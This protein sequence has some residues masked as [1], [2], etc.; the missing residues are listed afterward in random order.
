[1]NTHADKTPENNSQSVAYS[2]PKPKSSGEST[3]QFVD[4]RPEAIAQRKLHE[5][6]NN[7]PRVKQLKAYQEMAND[8][9][10]V[11]QL[12]VYQAISDN[13]TSQP[14]Q[15]KE[16]LE[17]ETLQGKFEPIQKKENNT[18]LPDNLKSGIENLSG[19]SMDDVKVQ[20]NSDKPSQLQAHAFAQGTHIHIASGQEK[21]LPHEAWHVVQQKQGRVK[22]TMQL[23]D[24][25]NINDD[26]GLEKE[27]DVMGEKALQMKKELDGNNTYQKVSSLNHTIVQMKAREAVVDWLVTHL[28]GDQN[29]SLF[30]GDTE[31]GW[32][33]GELPVEE[34][35][36]ARGQKIVVDDEQIFLSR[37]GS[38]QENP[39]K[40]Q[41]E[42]TKELKHKWYLVLAVGDVNYEG[43]NVYIR[44]ETMKFLKAEPRE[45][46]PMQTVEIPEVVVLGDGISK[47]LTEIKEA[48][49][50]SALKRRRSFLQVKYKGDH[51][52]LPNGLSSGWNW[53]QYDEGQDVAGDM[54]NPGFRSYIK[55][56]QPTNFTLSARYG[57]DPLQAP[58]AFLVM[59]EWQPPSLKEASGHVAPEDRFFYIRWLIGHPELKGGGSAVM[60]RAKEKAIELQQAIYVQVAYSA[61]GW[62]RGTG[63]EVVQEGEFREGEGYGDTLLKYTPPLLPLPH[64]H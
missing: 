62:Y 56:N 58:I 26:A 17:E 34:G 41:A 30:G 7:S 39:E 42:M 25:V 47:R 1:M 38:N 21:H 33:E 48:W 3:L 23:K 10:Q 40:R 35:E 14:A 57:D 53:D 6:I 19:Y 52:E 31:Q 15:R 24:K 45:Q 50:A 36:L 4:I 54:A 55:Q 22:P 12:R 61:V 11:K 18:G 64:P 20:Y 51:N 9:P 8:S 32:Q 27:A 46:R 49:Q 43:K 28:V 2:L 5:E 13:F 59:E 29:G 37:R 16:N 63:F 60:T 44:S